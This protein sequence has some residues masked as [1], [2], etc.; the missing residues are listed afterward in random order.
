MSMK[1]RRTRRKTVDF[2]LEMWYSPFRTNGLSE[3]D[4]GMANYTEEQW[5]ARKVELMEKCF[6]C[7]AERGLHGTGIRVLASE[8]IIQSYI[9]ISRTWTT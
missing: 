9:P 1:M 3:R 2:F 7:F 6:D 4:E 5:Y 8:S